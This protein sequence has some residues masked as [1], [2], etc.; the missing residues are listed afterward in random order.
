[1]A[2]SL[3]RALIRRLR[4]F[5]ARLH[6][7]VAIVL[8]VAVGWIVA[9]FG[10]IVTGVAD[11]VAAVPGG[12][13]VPTPGRLAI[14][15]VVLFALSALGSAT[16][17]TGTATARL[18]GPSEPSAAPTTSTEIVAVAPSA[19]ATPSPASSPE[20]TPD[21]T[22]SPTPEATPVPTPE[23]TPVPTPKPTPKPTFTFATSGTHRSKPF[24]ITLPARV[25]YNFTG[26]GNFIASIEATDGSGS[27]GQ[28]A[29]VIGSTKA[30]TWLYGDGVAD[31]AYIDVIASGRYSIKVTSDTRAA[32]KELPV[33]F[34]GKWGLTTT[35][36]SAGGD[37]AVNYSHK[38]SG[39]FIVQLIDVESGST[40]DLL[41]NEIGHVSDT[42]YAYGLFGDYAFDV[43]ASGSWTLS[44][45]GQ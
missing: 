34:S 45:T 40:E 7:I 18:S 11:A 22:P 43:V 10:L 28:I 21:P 33:G 42:T 35:P 31:R 37:V 12:R 1:V 6:P 19:S 32:A 23:P 2:V 5:F 41:V 9:L 36:F 29:N 26:S 20:A 39:N 14:G 27:L 4:A 44:V 16:R 13:R 17:P 8:F 38:G 24:V 15:V 30:T 3:S 25:D